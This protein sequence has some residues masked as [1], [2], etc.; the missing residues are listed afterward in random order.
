MDHP[1]FEKVQQLDLNSVAGLP[2]TGC[3]QSL[4]QAIPIMP[5]YRDLLADLETPISVY[6]KVARE[7]FCF[8]KE[9]VMGGEHMARYSCIGIDPYMV[10]TH[11]GERATLR[12]LRQR[13]AD[14]A[15]E[16][17]IPC[18]DPL[19]LIQAELDRYHLVMP[20]GQEHEALPGF[21]GGAFGYLAYETAA[22][23][24]H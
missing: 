19:P 14:V 3:E 10:L 15:L 6:C 13:G 24:E 4:G 1:T 12:W 8:L 9:S 16:E 20:E 17:T 21:S 7:P 5:L 22:R 23:F 18:Y 11:R 2:T